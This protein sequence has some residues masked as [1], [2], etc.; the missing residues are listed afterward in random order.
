MIKRN[1]RKFNGFDFSE[2]SE[3]YTSKLETLNKMDIKQI[4]TFCDILDIEKK[5]L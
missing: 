1:I 3:Q 4:K 5:G 2:D